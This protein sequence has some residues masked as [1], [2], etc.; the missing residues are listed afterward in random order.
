MLTAPQPERIAILMA[1][2]R[3][4]DKGSVDQLMELLYP[5]LRRM[6]AARMRRE[7]RANSWQ[8]TLLVNELYVELLRNSALGGEAGGNEEERAA[9]LGL[10]GFL[11]KRLLIL[12]SRPLSQR[13][14]RVDTGE[15]ENQSS[16]GGDAE[17]LQF[18]EGLLTDLEEI[19]PRIRSVVE[20]RIFEG[21]T[22]EEI[23]ARLGCSARSVTTYWGFARNWLSSRLN[24]EPGD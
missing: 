13:V 2:L 20:L 10:A 22:A 24:G 3:K 15:L 1:G 5:E 9:F 11:M 12:H 14:K 16:A 4:G 23:G 21:L 7:G 8:P 17:S 18:V 19:D 6:A